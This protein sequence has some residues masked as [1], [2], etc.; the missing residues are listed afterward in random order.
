VTVS[1]R[2]TGLDVDVV[3]IL[4]DGDPKWYGN[5]VSQGRRFVPKDEHSAASGIR[6]QAQARAG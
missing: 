2:G 1:F 5:L 3:P 6:R 4:Y